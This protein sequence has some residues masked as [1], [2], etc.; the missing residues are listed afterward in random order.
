M[1]KIRKERQEVWD[2]Y[3]NG[4]IN[5]AVLP[6]A[7]GYGLSFFV[8]GA[9]LK[10]HHSR[11]ALLRDLLTPCGDPDCKGTDCGRRLFANA[12]KNYED[13]YTGSAKECLVLWQ[14]SVLVCVRLVN[15]LMYKSVSP[16]DTSAIKAHARAHNLFY[17]M[18]TVEIAYAKRQH[19]QYDNVLVASF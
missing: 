19:G 9:D 16:W 12:V 8:T 2:K 3:V 1:D 7:N 10:R 14:D 18:R 11:I 6:I 13:F 4:A 17:D 15:E 5:K